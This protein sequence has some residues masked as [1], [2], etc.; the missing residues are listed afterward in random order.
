M[1]LAWIYQSDT[2]IFFGAQGERYNK[3]TSQSDLCNSHEAE[4]VTIESV[5]DSNL[6]KQQLRTRYKNNVV[7]GLTGKTL[8]TEHVFFLNFGVVVKHRQNL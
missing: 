1:F 2:D 8:L 4:L 6:I 5:H 3:M 7:S